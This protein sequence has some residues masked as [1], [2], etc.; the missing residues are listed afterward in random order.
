MDAQTSQ[1]KRF[2]TFFS[3]RKVTVLAVIC[4]GL[5]DVMGALLQDPGTLKSTVLTLAP[6]STSTSTVHDS[7]LLIWSVGVNRTRGFSFRASLVSTAPLRMM[8]TINTAVTGADWQA[9][10]PVAPVSSFLLPVFTQCEYAIC[11]PFTTQWAHTVAAGPGVLHPC[12]VPQRSAHFSFNRAAFISQNQTPT[13]P[14]PSQLTPPPSPN[15]GGA[16]DVAQGPG[17]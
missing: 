12:R 7:I 16:Y 14:P 8:V 11:L 13:L 5:C 3:D 6:P 10:G 17:V 9:A 15:K 4:W 2:L 1:I